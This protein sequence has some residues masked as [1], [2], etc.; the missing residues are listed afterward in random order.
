MAM[1][2][3]L[4]MYWLKNVFKSNRYKLTYHSVFFDHS[5]NISNKED[6]DFEG[7]IGE[8]KINKTIKKSEYNFIMIMCKYV[9][10]KSNQK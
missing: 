4:I 3:I 8:I 1:T 10:Y 6:Y 2:Y 5:K 7:S 9:S